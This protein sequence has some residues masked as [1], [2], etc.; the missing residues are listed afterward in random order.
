MKDNSV[1][2]ICDV[3]SS[4]LPNNHEDKPSSTMTA[5]FKLYNIFNKILNLFSEQ[6]ISKISFVNK[7]K[8]S[9]VS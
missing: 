4:A 2:I 1:S 7:G 3:H 9:S 6:I 5:D 8:Y